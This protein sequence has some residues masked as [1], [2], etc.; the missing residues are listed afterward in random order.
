MRLNKN[1]RLKKSL[2]VVLYFGFISNMIYNIIIVLLPK[3]IGGNTSRILE[4][5]FWLMLFNYKTLWFFIVLSF[6]VTLSYSFINLIV[7]NAKKRLAIMIVVF[8]FSLCPIGFI[9]A[10]FHY[11]G[12]AIYVTFS[13][14]LLSLY[15][16][17]S[18]KTLFKDG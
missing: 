9:G 6:V 16:L 12:V 4:P 1:Q 17:V 11:L 5:E 10:V 18:E 3:L 7:N 13:F 2:T 14:M 15:Y 8:L